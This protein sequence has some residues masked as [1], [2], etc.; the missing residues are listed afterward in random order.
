MWIYNRKQVTKQTNKKQ[1]QICK[2]REQTDD[3]QRE[4]IWGMGEMSEGE[5][6]KQV[7][8]YG[9]SK[10]WEYKIQHREYSPWWA[11]SIV[12]VIEGTVVVGIA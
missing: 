11:K 8:S 2:Y 7:S 6:K 3:C 10:S 9:M 1:N 5:W 4:G 12:L